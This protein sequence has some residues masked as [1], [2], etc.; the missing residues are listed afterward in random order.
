MMA[1]ACTHPGPCAPSCHNYRKP[2]SGLE[3]K[4]R[5]RLI[6]ARNVVHECNQILEMIEELRQYK[7][8][9]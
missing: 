1:L 6:G 2:W 7:G 4:T 5:A 8:A 9:F 3:D